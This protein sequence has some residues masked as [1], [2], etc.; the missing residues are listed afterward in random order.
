MRFERRFASVNGVSVFCFGPHQGE[1]V[2]DVWDSDPAYMQELM[3]SGDLAPEEIEVVQMQK[4]RFRVPPAQPDPPSGG[5]PR[6]PVVIDMEPGPNGC[7]HATSV[8][9]KAVGPD[10]KFQ[11]ASPDELLGFVFGGGA[12]CRR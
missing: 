1:P 8:R 12:G 3:D 11:V 7:Y 9:E 5:G 4:H 10:V 6:G 2:P